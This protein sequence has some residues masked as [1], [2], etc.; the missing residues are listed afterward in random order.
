MYILTHKGLYNSAK[1]LADGIKQKTGKPIFVYTERNPEDSRSPIIRWGN[2]QHEY[3]FT[4]DTRFN[5]RGSISVCGSKARFSEVL[6]RSGIPHVEYYRGVVPERFPVV[7]RT[8]LNGHGG[9]GIIICESKE[10]F[11]R[12]YSRDVWSYWFNFEFELG[13]HILNGKV[14]RVFKKVWEKTETEPKYPIRNTD[15]GYNFS[16]RDVEK[17]K[18]LQDIVTQFYRV[19]PINMARLDIAWDKANKTYR[20]IEANS[21]PSLSENQNTLHM[22]T[23]FLLANIK[24]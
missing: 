13:V 21:A 22:Y 18:K 3:E 2:G 1:L 24:F 14:Q 19:V 10:D 23:E 12:N 17:Y 15:K 7:I 6:S 8:I 16:L 20:I 4:G 5:D 11:T 9:E